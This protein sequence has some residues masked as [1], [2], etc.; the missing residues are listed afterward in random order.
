MKLRVLLES[1]YSPIRAGKFAGV[2]AVGAVC[3]NLVLVALATTGLTPE[4]A[5]FFGIET[6][7]VVMFMLNERW[8][9]GEI[10]SPGLV[11]V[12][13]RLGTS[14]LVRIGGIAVQLIVFSIVFRWFHVSMAFRGVDL[15][16]LVASGTGIVSGM[17][18]NYVAESIFTWRVH[19]TG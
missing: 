13:R 7:I 4:I 6:A 11:P 15:W 9:F 12:L 19:R 10:G 3:D 16:L 14:N 17:I 2:G 1:L 18:V 8:T 5:K